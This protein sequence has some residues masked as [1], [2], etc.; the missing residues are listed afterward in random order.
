MNKPT[1]PHVTTVDQAR[2]EV[3][4][5]MS[6]NSPLYILDW[7]QALRLS[8]QLDTALALLDESYDKSRKQRERGKE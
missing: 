8:C 6:E 4:V 1:W 5:K 2:G 7:L 3:G